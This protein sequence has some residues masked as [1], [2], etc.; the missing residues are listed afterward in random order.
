MTE[1]EIYRLAKI[2]VKS[3]REELKTEEQDL[4]N[5][6]LREDK[7]HQKLYRRYGEEKFLK[8]KFEMAGKIDWKVDY[9]VFMLKHP[10]GRRSLRVTQWLKYAAVLILPLVIF[11]WLKQENTPVKMAQMT[12]APQALPVLI[13]GSGER[14]LLTDTLGMKE[15]DGI[16]VE[17][18]GS[19]VYYRSK[20]TESDWK[21]TSIVFNRIE[22]PRG[23]EYLLA[24]SDGTEI[25]LNSESEVRYPVKFSGQTREVFVQGEAFF[26]VAEDSLYPFIVHAGQAKIEVLGTEFNVRSYEDETTVATTLL[27]GS[28]R[29]TDEGS[30]QTCILKPG[31]QGNIDKKNGR[32]EIRE[33]DTYLYTAWKEGRFV[34][35]NA[36]MEDLLNTLARWYDLTLFYQNEAAKDI[37][38]TGDMSR[39]GEFSQL[40]HIIEMN[41]LVGFNIHDRTIIVSLK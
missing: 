28:V 37:R 39:M 12:K 20:D 24:L 38:F 36:R 41:E 29:L 14:I 15:V 25:W 4:L 26:K 40:L 33:V 9:R 3:F 23:A 5:Q 16:L 1:E 17:G 21:D 6:W 30:K 10:S 8:D 19:G 35:R 22:V 2:I 27:S 18:K 31:Q 32:T 34:F 7:A 13:V 11:L